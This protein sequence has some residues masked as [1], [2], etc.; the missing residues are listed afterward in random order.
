MSQSTDTLLADIA[1]M[2]NII[3]K[4]LYYQ[5]TNTAG[6]KN[7][8]PVIDIAGKGSDRAKFHYG[9]TF[10]AV[11][12]ATENTTMTPQK[13]SITDVDITG[14]LKK[15]PVWIS[16]Q[17]LKGQSLQELIIGSITNQA[18][19]A[20]NA[21]AE[22]DI[23]DLATSFTTNAVGTTNTLIT[24]TDLLSG[25]NKLRSTKG[26]NTRDLFA[27]GSPKMLLDW[28]KDLTYN[29]FNVSSGYGWNIPENLKNTVFTTSIP[30]D[31][32]SIAGINIY[33]TQVIENN[34]S[35]DHV[36]FIIDRRAIGMVY[37]SSYLEFE[38]ARD[39]ANDGYWLYYRMFYGVGVV[40]EG[41]GC[42]VTADGL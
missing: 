11:E 8:I 9:S 10:T 19:N 27:I 29:G 26:V 16:D 36:G 32:L 18:V 14:T 21:K 42:K 38:L 33:S 31:G 7:M 23:T 1:G 34:G 5:L 24:Y 15:V 22:K 41:W 37:D 13:Y 2:K 6:L 20:L 40:K 4:E 25:L 35:G 17:A 39:H 3:H 30:V 28:S 12:S